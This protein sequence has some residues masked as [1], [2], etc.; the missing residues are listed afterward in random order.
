MTRRSRVMVSPLSLTVVSVSCSRTTAFMSSA[1]FLT[2]CWARLRNQSGTPALAVVDK[3]FSR[4][5]NKTAL[6]AFLSIGTASPEDRLLFVAG[7]N[8]A[9]EILD[10]WIQLQT[11]E[12]T[13]DLQDALREQLCT[14]KLDEI[15]VLRVPEPRRLL[16]RDSLQD[17]SF[18]NF[19]THPVRFAKGVREINRKFSLRMFK[20]IQLLGLE[21]IWRHQ[22]AFACGRGIGRNFNVKTYYKGRITCFPTLDLGQ[23][24]IG[25]VGEPSSQFVFQIF[26]L[27]RFI[28]A[29][30]VQ[31][32][33]ERLTAFKFGDHSPF[34]GTVSIQCHLRGPFDGS[35]VICG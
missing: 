35:F 5:R 2:G 33:L 19:D 12:N 31:S 15:L 9:E 3:R 17:R 1:Y 11:E 25:P 20:G 32:V 13:V 7:L 30:F 22:Q 16:L 23:F 28:R 14:I 6:V 24:D 4:N 26:F 18:W 27:T 34:Q 29:Q 10:F 8:L 21:K